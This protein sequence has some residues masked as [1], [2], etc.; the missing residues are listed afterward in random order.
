LVIHRDLPAQ[1]GISS[2]PRSTK[3]SSRRRDR[4]ADA[5][6]DHLDADHGEDQTH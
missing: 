4:A 6:D 1:E 3:D 5:L 2:L